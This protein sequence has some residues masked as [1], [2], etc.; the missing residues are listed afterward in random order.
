MSV[1][2]HGSPRWHRRSCL[3]TDARVCLCMPARVSG[4]CVFVCGLQWP[5]GPLSITLVGPHGVQSGHQCQI[6]GSGGEVSPPTLAA[7]KGE[8]E[9]EVRTSPQHY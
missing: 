8:G 3:H 5:P 2:A 6:I 7:G 1:A 9:R 4:V